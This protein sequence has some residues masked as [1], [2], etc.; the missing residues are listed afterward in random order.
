MFR[1]SNMSKL[2]L[3]SFHIYQ[4]VEGVLVYVFSQSVCQLHIFPDLSS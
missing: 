2:V 1:V 4:L 3:W